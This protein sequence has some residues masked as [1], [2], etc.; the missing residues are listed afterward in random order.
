MTSFRAKVGDDV[1]H[2]DHADSVRD[3][4]QQYVADQFGHD[5]GVLIVDDTGFQAVHAGRPGEAS[6]DLRFA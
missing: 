3:D 1:L 5:D 6:E 2:D 4:L